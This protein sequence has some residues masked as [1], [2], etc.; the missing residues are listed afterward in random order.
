MFKNLWE[1]LK[2]KTFFKNLGLAILVWIL[3][4]GA[5]VFYLSNYTRHGEFIVLP[6]L[7][8]TQL[9]KAEEQ[10][11]SLDLKYVVI[12]SVYVENSPPGLVFKQNPYAG[13]HVK[14]GR[15]IY[16][17]T[18]SMLP[19]MVEM[20]DLQDKSLRQAKNI[21]ENNGLKLGKVTLV[22]AAFAGIV[23][24]QLNKGRTIDPGAKIAKGTVIDL[25]VGRGST[26]DTL[27]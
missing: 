17:Y 14:K 13:S 2:S 15:N 26:D 27:P 1:F 12:D 10:L 21:I 25:D 9:T 22:P 16:L 24:R 19:P 7:S 20:P 18:T 23:V 11:K 3:F 5:A 4:F 8:K 6:D